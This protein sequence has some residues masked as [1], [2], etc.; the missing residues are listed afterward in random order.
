LCTQ[1]EE[2]EEEAEEEEPTKKKSSGKG[3]AAA[4]LKQPLIDFTGGGASKP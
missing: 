1:E 2:E 3:W 4:Y